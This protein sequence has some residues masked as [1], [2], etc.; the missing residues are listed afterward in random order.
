MS[1][2]IYHNKDYPF[3]S[4]SQTTNFRLFQTE[5][6]CRWQFQIWWQFQKVLQIGRKHLGKRRNCSLRAISPFSHSVF[7]RLVLQT[8]QNQDFLA[9]GLIHY[10][11]AKFRPIQIESTCR[12]LDV[13]AVIKFVSCRKTLNEKKKMCY[14][15]FFPLFVPQWCLKKSASL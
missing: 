12:Q 2:R 11:T 14:Q 10:L 4:L 6:V 9:K 7:L 15:H 3:F 8:C 5:R 1:W 13:A